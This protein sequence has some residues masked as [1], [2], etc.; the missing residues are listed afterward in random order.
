MSMKFLFREQIDSLLPEEKARYFDNLNN[1]P[2]FKK[3]Y[4]EWLSSNKGYSTISSAREEN[5]YFASKKVAGRYSDFSHEETDFLII[6][7]KAVSD[8]NKLISKYKTQ[9]DERWLE[10]HRLSIFTLMYERV[11]T[12]MGYDQFDHS[13]RTGIQVKRGLDH[14]KKVIKE[15]NL[16]EVC[17]YI[18]ELKEMRQFILNTPQ[19]R[20]YYESEIDNIDLII[21]NAEEDRDDLTRI[22]MHES[23]K[24]YF[25]SKKK[26]VEIKSFYQK[27]I[28]NAYQNGGI[29]Y[30]DGKPQK[31]EGVK[32]LKKKQ[33]KTMLIGGII[34]TSVI[35]LSIVASALTLGVAP[36]AFGLVAGISAGVSAATFIGAQLITR[37][38]SRKMRKGFEDSWAQLLTK[39]EL[40]LNTSVCEDEF[41]SYWMEKNAHR[42]NRL[43]GA[44]REQAIQMAYSK[45]WAAYQYEHRC[46]MDRSESKWGLLID[47][48][49]NTPKLLAQFV[50][51]DAR[52]RV[53]HKELVEHI[54]LYP[55]LYYKYLPQIT[56]VMSPEMD[57]L[58]RKI[59]QQLTADQAV[60]II[61]KSNN[62]S[63]MKTDPPGAIDETAHDVSKT[64]LAAAKDSVFSKAHD[65]PGVT[66]K[67][68]SV[69]LVLT[70]IEEQAIE[71]GRGRKAEEIVR[72][73]EFA[74]LVE[75][76]KS[77]PAA[78]E[79]KVLTV[80]DVVDEDELETT[81]DTPTSEDESDDEFLIDGEEEGSEDTDE[82]VE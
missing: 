64:N 7:D 44:Q 37:L 57:L 27:Q 54:T 49:K 67:H 28:E 63:F 15:K 5:T 66:S 39:Q 26:N 43:K 11:S 41:K 70:A 75:E 10:D 19:L 25:V 21:K 14:Y 82:H 59:A 62:P 77:E 73:T 33:G 61:R 2:K 79:P 4:F 17:K 23:E 12:L 53:A 38:R 45:A 18:D 60:A 55:E 24:A 34:A 81:T 9:I 30:I 65:A 13:K 78:E 6:L 52:S 16:A 48:I 42:Y 8:R 47:K 56:D 29:L 22:I 20:E 35:G 32:D 80:A 3:K 72:T 58:F 51:H 36:A 68:D 46:D 74:V 69:D 40:S 50:P 31:V 1:N 71:Y 76:K